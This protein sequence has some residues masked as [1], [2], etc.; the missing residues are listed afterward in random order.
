METVPELRTG[1]LLLRA[2]RDEDLTPYAAM[3]GD[4]RVMEHFPST[5]TRAECEAQVENI[6]R[7]FAERGFGLWAVEVPGVAP[8][9]GF[10]GLSVPRF[11]AHFTPC[12]EAGWRIA[13]EHWGQ[14]YATE[15]ARAAVAFG[16]E[17]LGLGE[18]VSFTV[19]ANVRSRRV[20][21]KL[22]F[23][24]DPAEDFDHPR[25]P[26]GHALRR[27]VLYRLSRGRWELTPA[28]R[29]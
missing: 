12:V 27:H 7:H 9:I 3:C 24:H 16:F 20:M 17:R 15:A 21:E 14:G 29:P 4:P 13:A 19:P 23:T 1:R 28:S 22:G 11:E 6:R 18:L 8:F 5:L 26:E 25:L 10:T 2:W